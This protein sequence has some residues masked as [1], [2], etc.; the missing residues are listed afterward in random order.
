[1]LLGMAVKLVSKVRSKSEVD[2]IL[3][4]LIKPM[5]GINHPWPDARMIVN[6]DIDTPRRESLSRR[7]C[8]LCPMTRLLTHHGA[9]LF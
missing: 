6:V 2:G 7:I 3:T 9:F 8:L 4:G 5:K 1:M